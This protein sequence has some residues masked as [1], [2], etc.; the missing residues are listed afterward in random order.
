MKTDKDIRA[1]VLQMPCSPG[2]TEK[3]RQKAWSFVRQAAQEGAGLIVLPELFNVGYDLKILN[4]LDYSFKKE[5]ESC[6]S[7]AASEKIYIVCGLLEKEKSILYNSQVVFDR[8]GNIVAK[9]RKN[10]LFPLSYE[11]K[12]FKRGTETAVFS[13]EGF[14]FG[15]AICYDLRFP[16]IFRDYVDHG[17]DAILISSAFPFPRL[18]HWL[19]LVKSQA[20]LNQLYIVAGNRSGK[21]ND[22]W[23]VGNSCIIDPWGSIL[24][25][26]DETE[27]GYRISEISPSR[28]SE[29]RSA[30]PALYDRQK[31]YKR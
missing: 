19:T 5:I 18:E 9:Y 12:I 30:M 25:S 16:E 8:E 2:D 31:Q 26:M 7:V 14:T 27:E 17:C 1:A 13:A 22:S 11:H 10:N 6:S 15:L 3:N 21:D 28:V 24:C 29:I 23:F 4:D 20:V